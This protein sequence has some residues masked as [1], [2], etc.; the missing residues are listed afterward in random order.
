M[1]SWRHH[2]VRTQVQFD[3]TQ[4]QA[5]KRAAARHSVSMSEVVRKAVDRA[6]GE[7][8]GVSH[9][10]K[11]QRA[12]SAVGSVRGGAP[13]TSLRHDDFLGDDHG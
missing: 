10:Q 6:M 5:L 7:E 3:D 4:F 8:S 13:D 12:L 9:Q 2:V 11:V 1:P